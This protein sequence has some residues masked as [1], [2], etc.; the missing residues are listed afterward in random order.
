MRTMIVVLL[1]LFVGGA[2]LPA[3]AGELCPVTQASKVSVMAFLGERGLT[4][5]GASK[6]RLAACKEE[7][8]RCS[9]DA[10]W[11]RGEGIPRLGGP[12]PTPRHRP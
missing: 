8:A 12:G 11:A 5:R 1:A 7:G 6:L 3:A 10:D 4:A 9:T 2:A